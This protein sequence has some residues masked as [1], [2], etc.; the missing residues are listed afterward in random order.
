MALSKRGSN[1]HQRRISLKHLVSTYTEAIK[2]WPFKKAPRS[3]VPSFDVGVYR[4]DR[5]VGNDM[6]LHSLSPD[7][8]FALRTT[9]QFEGERIVH[10]PQCD[11]MGAKWTTI[12]ATVHGSIYKIAIQTIGK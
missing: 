4:L 5:Q 3:S 10:A 11:F 7:E 1:G 6:S 9:I 2:V 8:L 12:L